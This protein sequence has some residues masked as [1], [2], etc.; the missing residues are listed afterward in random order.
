MKTKNIPYVTCTM[1]KDPDQ[2]AHSCSSIRVFVVRKQKLQ[3][4]LTILQK[5]WNIFAWKLIITYANNKDCEQT[6]PTKRL[7]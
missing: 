2:H 4:L 7:L 5:A 3:V 6:A 1:R